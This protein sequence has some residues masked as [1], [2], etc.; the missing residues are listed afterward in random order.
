MYGS[1][2]VNGTYPSC[3]QRDFSIEL[4]KCQIDAENTEDTCSALPG[5]LTACPDGTWNRTCYP[6]SSCD[7]KDIECVCH[8]NPK[9]TDS[10][11]ETKWENWQHLYPPVKGA[12][13]RDV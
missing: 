13:Y 11:R 5:R 1:E 12:H 4:P 6:R 10:V 7:M 3:D 9:M 8:S 2:K